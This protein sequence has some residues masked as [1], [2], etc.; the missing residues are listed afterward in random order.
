M[1]IND[2]V[3]ML[4][5]L[6]ALMIINIVVTACFCREIIELRR[7]MSELEYTEPVIGGEEVTM[8]ILP[9]ETPCEEYTEPVVEVTPEPE[10][11][12]LYTDMDAVALAKLVW[13][14][15]RGVPDYGNVTSK[16]QKAAVIWTVLNRY[17]AGYS[18][19]IIGVI[20][21]PQ[22]FHG[23]DKENPVD[24][25]LLSLAYDVLDRW[26]YEKRGIVDI[27]RVIPA[28]YFWFRGDG[29]YNHFRNEYKS[30]NTWDWSWGDPYAM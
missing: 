2:V 23:Y 8:T 9:V 28:D 17:D 29:E 13:G 20:T 15:A 10:Y 21:A 30:K 4:V 5:F 7:V 22:Q 27:G 14:E 12:V 18:D 25:D 16:C 3:Y 26:Y 6:S 11:P 19:S 1:K 24:E